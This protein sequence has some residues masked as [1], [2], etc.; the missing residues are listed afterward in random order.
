VRVIRTEFYF[1]KQDV[2]KLERDINPGI[3]VAFFNLDPEDHVPVEEFV[4]IFKDFSVSA[5]TPQAVMNFLDVSLRGLQVQ[6]PEFS[7]DLSVFD[8]LN[9]PITASVFESTVIIEQSPPM[10]IPFGELAKRSTALGIGTFIGFGLA[11]GSFPLMI[12]TVPVGIIVVGAA[13]GVSKGLE[14]GL[15]KWIRDFLEPRKQALPPKPKK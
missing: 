12:I 3:G 11:A 2:I 6:D 13:V 7:A 9:S 15:D 10:G 1:D 14:N 4:N 8:D 5:A